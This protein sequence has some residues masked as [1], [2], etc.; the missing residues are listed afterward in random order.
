MRDAGKE[1][2]N[3]Q[4]ALWESNDKPIYYISKIHGDKYIVP[5]KEYEKLNKENI[6]M[7]KVLEIIINK[8]VDIHYLEISKTVEE[9]NEYAE[10]ETLFG[11]KLTEDEFKLV[12]EMQKNV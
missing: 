7:K 5:K 2:R 12:K 4:L 8:Y 1:L 6:E 10:K 3:L 11:M 9:Y